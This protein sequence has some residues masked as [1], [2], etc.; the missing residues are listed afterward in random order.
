M[1]SVDEERQLVQLLAELIDISS[2]TGEERKIGEYLEQ[3]LKNLGLEVS[4]Q[5]VGPH[6]FNLV[7]RSSERARVLL[8]THMDTVLPQLP[9]SADQG[10]IRGRGACDAK[11][12][13]AAMISAAETV[14]RRGP[15]GIG[16]L[17]LVGE[18]EDSDGARKAADLDLDSEYVILGEP[19]ENKVATGQKGTLVF[20]VEVSGKAAHSA[21][22]E[23]GRSAINVLVKLLDGW[24]N[25]DWG[26]DPVIGRNTLNIGRVSGGVGPNVVAPDAVAEGIFRVGT[27][28]AAVRER[29]FA[30]QGD[31]IL[32]RVL[33]SSEPMRLHVPVGVE[34]TVAPFGSDA[35]YLQPLG[36][37]IMLGPGSIEHAHSLGEQVTIDQL[38][39]ARD[40]YVKLIEQLGN[41]G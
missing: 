15:A 17:F 13:M 6:R 23:K 3:V 18:E 25:E 22:P 4:R 27:T 21:C 28:T 24:I 38:V 19:T 35:P 16:L 11:G 41:L 12:A 40:Q 20:R 30:D 5:T 33:S 36:K 32:I 37:V 26:A 39:D 2:P 9:F 14:L 10:V 7:A 8:C 34:T 31:D 1:N 29:L